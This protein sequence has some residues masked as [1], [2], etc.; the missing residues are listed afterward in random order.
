MRKLPLRHPGI[1]AIISVGLSLLAL[2]TDTTVAS[3]PGLRRHFDTSVPQ[4]QLTLPVFVA[5][6]ASYH[7]TVG[8]T[9]G[10]GRV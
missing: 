7:F 4:A 3:M 6:L 9:G 2:A 5:V 10:R 1:A 8:R